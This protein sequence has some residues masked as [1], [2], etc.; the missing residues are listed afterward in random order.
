MYMVR[1]F[2]LAEVQNPTNLLNYRNNENLRIF[3]PKKL[4]D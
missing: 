1:K 4:A 3:K 2:A